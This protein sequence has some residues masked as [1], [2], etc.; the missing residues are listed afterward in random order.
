MIVSV[1]E[2]FTVPKKVSVCIT[3]NWIGENGQITDDASKICAGRI[4]FF[5]SQRLILANEHFVEV[6]MAHVK[7]F[8]EHN[9]RHDFMEPVEIW[10]NMFK[11]FGLASFIPIEKICETCI[12]CNLLMDGES[13][14]AINPMRKKIL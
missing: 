3:A 6:S 7:W 13:V 9:A 2:K 12:T 1:F 5:F 11:P 10:Y 14:I 8:Q 4:E